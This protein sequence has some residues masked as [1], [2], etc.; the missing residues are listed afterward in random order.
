M[1]HSTEE[2]GRGPRPAR[3]DVLVLGAGVALGAAGVGAAWAWSDRS[4]GDGAAGRAEADA[5]E[6][7][8]A[9]RFVSSQLTAPGRAP[10]AGRG[11][12]VSGGLLFTTPRTPA[13]RGVV[14]DD[15][16]QPVWIE[17]DGNAAT[18]L[19]VQTYRGRPC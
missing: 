10:G 14:Y 15:R 13:F 6:G 11:A 5:A 17:P 1:S 18:D 16:A 19:R 12:M 3:R 2:A 4:R 7:T 9:G 8:R